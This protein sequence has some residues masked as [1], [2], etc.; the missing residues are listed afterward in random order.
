MVT[1]HTSQ[2]LCIPKTNTY[3]AGVDE[4]GR[5][6]LAGPVAVAAVV[7]PD[8]SSPLNGLNDSKRLTAKQREALYPQIVRSACAYKII[9]VD[10]AT[11][12]RQN[13]LQATLWGMSQALQH[14]AA[15]AD[16]ARI[17]GKHI[18]LDVP[19]PAEAVVGG[20]RQDSAIMAASILAK[21][22]RDR[23]MCT[24]DTKYPQYL[25]KQH[26]G[27][28]TALHLAALQ[29]YGACPEHRRSFAPVRKAMLC[30][31]R[32]VAN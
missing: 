13:I 1:T 11:I 17:D 7:F 3:Y 18:P 32:H 28:G 20:D 31:R 23:Y 5:G 21:V 25:F 24:L 27:Y 9:M 14:V 12:D 6:P 4:A 29:R 8:S 30:P 10:V 19:M 22:T 15:Y 16:F 2:S 26:K